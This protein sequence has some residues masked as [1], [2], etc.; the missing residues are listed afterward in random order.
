MKPTRA[1]IALIVGLALSSASRA[2]ILGDAQD[3]GG[4]YTTFDMEPLRNKL[5][6][7]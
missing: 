4:S 1:A 2:A 6:I 7:C 5:W 3:R